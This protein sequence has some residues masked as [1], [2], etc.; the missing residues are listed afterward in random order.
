M[1]RP[2]WFVQLLKKSFPQ[3]FWVAR[4]THNPVLGALIDRMLFKG[5]ELV[6]LPSNRSIL[7]QENIQSTDNTILP[8]QVLDHFIEQASHRWIMNFCICRESN[9]C[10]DYPRQYGCIFLGEAVQQINPKLGRLVS[11]TE[12]LE[13]AQRCREAGLVHMIGRN[14][15]DMMWL[16]AG[17]GEKLLTI[18]NCC[19]C[20]CLWKTLPS[21]NP[22]ISSKIKRLPEVH[23]HV[24]ELCIGC[25]ECT[26][27]VCFVDAIRV[28]DGRAEI[29]EE[30]RGCGRCVETCPNG[31]IELKLENSKYVENAITRITSRVKIR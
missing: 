1:S 4:L 9:Q 30:C 5:D 3:R 15:L 23:L 25:G 20:C 8:S 19:P 26:Q 27:G 28:V 29:S 12:A 16:G 17:P 6:Y 11:K 2:M 14:K 7:I 21:L 22:Q 10:Q 24:N 13:H 18:C 31:A